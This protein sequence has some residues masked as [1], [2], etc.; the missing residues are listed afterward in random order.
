MCTP[1]LEDFRLR[2]SQHKAK[3][4]THPAQLPACTF[5]PALKGFRNRP[6]GKGSIE[7]VGSDRSFCFRNGVSWPWAYRSGTE[8][9]SFPGRCCYQRGTL[10][11]ASERLHLVKRK[12]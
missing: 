1:V 10:S 8:V 12:R 6:K 4:G 9:T 3:R 7:T 5:S 2:N 11:F